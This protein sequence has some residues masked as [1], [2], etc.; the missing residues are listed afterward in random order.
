MDSCDRLFKGR[1]RVMKIPMPQRG[2][3]LLLAGALVA[4]TTACAQPLVP[5][6]ASPQPVT[7]SSP[8]VLDERRVLAGEWEY[9]DS[10]VI[11]LKLDEWGN[12]NY[13]WK[14]GRL[15]TTALF[16][17]TWQG[18]W[19][20]KEND[21]EGG[22]TVEFSPDFSEGEGRWW[23]SRIGTDHAPTQKGGTFHMTR[24]GSDA[25]PLDR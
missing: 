8:G 5:R 12:G 18:M 25:I 21:R 15:E 14:E 1:S 16:G 20:Q 22:F 3:T 4:L 13:A 11:E 7:L 2:R 23:Y 10:A 24:K 9:E 6:E 17:H 19:F